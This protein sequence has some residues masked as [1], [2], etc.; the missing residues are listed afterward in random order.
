MTLCEL[1]SSS[2]QLYKAASNILRV[3]DICIGDLRELLARYGLSLILQPYGE[4]ITGSHWGESEAGIVGHNVFVRND[5][6][7]HSL[8]HETAHIVC[9]SGERRRALSQD[10]GGNDL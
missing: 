6:P 5:T 10:A 1:S 8:L 7:I 2:F 4:E 9:M 3:G